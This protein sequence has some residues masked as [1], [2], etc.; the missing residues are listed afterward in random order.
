MTIYDV[1]PTYDKDRPLLDLGRYHGDWE[2]DLGNG[3]PSVALSSTA[4]HQPLDFYPLAGT[5][6]VASERMAA[7]LLR[8]GNRHLRAHPASVDGRAC[9]VLLSDTPLDALDRTRSKFEVFRSNP[10]RIK[11]VR[12]FAFNMALIPS[13]PFAFTI[14]EA[15]GNLFV[16]EAAATAMREDGL[17]GAQTI[18]V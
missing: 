1:R 18:P 12:T 10:E 5:L 8:W 7:H 13:A 17:S 16:N 4:P 2:T 6:G 3:A 15:R 11:L 9:C 14:P